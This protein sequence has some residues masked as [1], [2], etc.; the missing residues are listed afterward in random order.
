MCCQC[1]DIYYQAGYEVV[2]VP[3]L[4]ATPT[5][6]PFG[7]KT[8]PTVT[9]EPAGSYQAQNQTCCNMLSTFLVIE[10]MTC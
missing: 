2:Q 3:L 10:M 9:Q 1:S 4:G 6:S 5:P 7:V 8:E